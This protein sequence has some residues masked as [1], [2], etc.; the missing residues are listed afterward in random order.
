MITVIF[1][2]FLGVSL[3]I[4][5]PVLTFFHL[6]K[7]S[8]KEVTVMLS[9][10]EMTVQWP[11][12]KM[13]IAYA[14]IKSYSAC[15]LH[16]DTGDVESVRISLKSGKKITLSATFGFCDIESLREFREAFDTLA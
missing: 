13:V 16:Q 6:K 5:L 9:A 12:K 2:F 10:T 14:D 4:F 7:K 11:F 3:L 1:F 8:S 15:R